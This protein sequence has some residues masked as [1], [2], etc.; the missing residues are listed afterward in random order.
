MLL[1]CCQSNFLL[2]EVS[3]LCCGSTVRG[4][5]LGQPAGVAAASSSFPM[6]CPVLAPL[7]AHVLGRI[8][9]VLGSTIDN[10]VG[11]GMHSCMMCCASSEGKASVTGIV[12][13]ST[14]ALPHL[15]DASA[16]VMLASFA[17]AAGLLPATVLVVLASA[18][19]VFLAF[20]LGTAAVGFGLHSHTNDSHW[21]ARA[22]RGHTSISAIHSTPPSFLSLQLSCTLYETGIKVV[23]LMSPY[24][25]GG[26]V[27][28]FGGAGVGKTV[29]I[30]ELIR[31]LA[32]VSSG[33]SLF[34]GVGERSREG[35]DLYSEMQDS[36]IIGLDSR[37]QCCGTANTT[38]DF[39]ASGNSE[40]LLVFGQMNETPGSRLRVPH[41]AV[42][43]A[44]HFRDICEADILIFVDDLFRFIQA[45]SELATLLGQMP[46]AV[47]YQPSLASE[48]GSI[49]ER[50][51]ATL[52]GSLT[53]VLQRYRELQ[54]IIAILG[55]EELSEEDSSF[56]MRAR[57]AE[58]LLS[59]PFFTAQTFTRM[60][61]PYIDIRDTT[62]AFAALLS[63]AY[64]CHPEYIFYV[65]G[66]I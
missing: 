13:L 52:T 34:A 18:A 15:H 43:V 63:G 1:L 58:R 14:A 5:C 41:A 20:G 57:K 37:P 39:K 24:K 49:Q 54:D 10:R 56:V 28:M 6:L 50:I 38:V 25:R 8:F 33:L 7:G 29:L 16:E 2:A 3:Q 22:L 36:G 42:T 48:L 60:P 23:D 27:G 4:V 21:A 66:Q 64:D 53:S 51:S 59:Q 17:A 9:N 40:V 31:N 19:S 62:S 12:L 65:T 61:G 32:A 46:S 26:K 45:G 30:M 11:L 44:E 35:S 47:G 55:L